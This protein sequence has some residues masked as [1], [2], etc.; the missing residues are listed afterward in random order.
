MTCITFMRG[1]WTKTVSFFSAHVNMADMCLS[2]VEPVY[3]EIEKLLQTKYKI[4]HVTIQ[5][6]AA[7]GKGENLIYD[8][9][10]DI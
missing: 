7:R 10:R 3:R 4:S 8:Q 9:G 2:D 5:A 1:W 6:E